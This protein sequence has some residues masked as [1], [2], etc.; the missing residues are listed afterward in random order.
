MKV[1]VGIWKIKAGKRQEF[2]LESKRVSEASKDESGLLSYSFSESH[3]EENTFIFFEE[4]KDDKAIS[5]HKSQ[6]YFKTF[7][8]N[9]KEMLV[10]DFSG[11]IYSINSIHSF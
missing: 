7:I 11:N 6:P 5:Y 9:T 2:I 4:W 3:L 1:V 8:E 10:E